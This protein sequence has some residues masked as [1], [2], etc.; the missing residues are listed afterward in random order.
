MAYVWRTFV[1][2]PKKRIHL[3]VLGLDVEIMLKWIF[4]KWDGVL[5]HNSDINRVLVNVVI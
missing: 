2:E 3:E 4:R 1:E 5:A